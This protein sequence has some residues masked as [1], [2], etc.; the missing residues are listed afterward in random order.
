MVALHEHKIAVGHKHSTV[1]LY[2]NDN[3]LAGDIQLS[4]G[5]A[6]PLMIVLEH[7]FLQVDV[8][9]VFQCAC[10]QNQGVAGFEHNVAAGNDVLSA[11]AYHGNDH[12]GG[13]LKLNDVL[14]DPQVVGHELNFDKVDVV[15]FGIFADALD[16]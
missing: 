2:H 8:P 13:K 9:V 5:K 14:A 1:A 7:D 15:F 10:T 11:T 12:T 6:V 4:D 3:G 16:A